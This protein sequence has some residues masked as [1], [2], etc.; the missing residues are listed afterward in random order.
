MYFFLLNFQK[1]E[2]DNRAKDQ[3]IAKLKHEKEEWFDEKIDLENKLQIS[4]MELK[5]AKEQI[6]DQKIKADLATDE[7]EIFKKKWKERNLLNLQNSSENIQNIL[8]S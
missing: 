1:F 8:N 7:L 4:I 5:S 3:V 6:Q 2:I